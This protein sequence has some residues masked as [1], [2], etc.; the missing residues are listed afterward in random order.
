MAIP[1]A[2]LTSG[3]PPM[4]GRVDRTDQLLELLIAKDKLNTELMSELLAMMKMMRLGQQGGM[5]VGGM[6]GIGGDGGEQC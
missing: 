6:G 3:S 2:S 4:P 5:V 1:P